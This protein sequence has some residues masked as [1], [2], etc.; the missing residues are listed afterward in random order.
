MLVR[1]DD[2]LVSRPRTENGQ[3]FLNRGVTWVEK[4]EL[5]KAIR[6]F[7]EVIRLSPKMQPLSTTVGWRGPRRVSSTRLSR[8]TTKPSDSIP[9]SLMLSTTAGLYGAI[10]VSGTRPSKTS[11][12]PSNSTPNSLML[13]TTA[14]PYGAIKVSST[15]R[16]KTTTKSSDSSLNLLTL[17][18]AA[19]SRGRRREKTRRPPRISPKPSGCRN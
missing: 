12:K 4:G 8:I 3:R 16:L 1:I 5:D 17:S 6:D 15:K 18:P 13:S 7:D 14:G 10:K 19:E 11:T 2:T 9:N